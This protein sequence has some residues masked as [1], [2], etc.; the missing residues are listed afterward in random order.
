MRVP[1]DKP[2][3]PQI[4]YELDIETIACVADVDG[5]GEVDIVDLLLVLA[6]WGQGGTAA[7][8]AA[9]VDDDGIVAVDDL[10]IIV[11]S[12]GVCR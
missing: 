6:L 5:S 3:S 7:S 2:V 9:D 12:W 11:G 4:V 10:L 1:V 8:D